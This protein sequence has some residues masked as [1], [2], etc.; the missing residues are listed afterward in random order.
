MSKKLFFEALAK[1][2]LG[3]I[4][5]GVLVFLPAGTLKYVNGWI[6]MGVLFIP[7]FIAGLVMMAKNPELLISRLDAKEKEKEQSLVVKLS[8]LMFVGGFVLA[9][10]D[11]RFNWLSF[12]EVLTYIGV[13]F[14]LLAYLL[15]AEVLR[16]NTYLSRTIKVSENQKV[17]DTGLYGIVRHPM[18]TATIILFLSMPLIL[19]SFISLLIF[20]PYPFLIAYRAINEEKVL[21]K[22]LEG[23]E[24]Y[25][26]KVKYRFIPYIW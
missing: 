22:E 17:V 20:L 8:G 24:E 3:V 4:L 23:Y 9:G 18:Y 12:P 7:M 13:F 6:F 15:Y 10:L 11:Y 16:E 2:F 21:L 26:K 25:T 19:G 5:V 14:F 1:F